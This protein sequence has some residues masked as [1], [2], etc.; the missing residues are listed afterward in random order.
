MEDLLAQKQATDRLYEISDSVKPYFV[1]KLANVK[2][3]L[4]EIEKRKARLQSDSILLSLT[5]HYLGALPFDERKKIRE[6]IQKRLLPEAGKCDLGEVFAV[7]FDGVV[8]SARKLQ[9]RAA[10]NYVSCDFMGEFLFLLG[11]DKEASTVLLQD[12]WGIA[13]EV[14]RSVIGKE[15]DLEAV[16]CSKL[17]AQGFLNHKLRAD[18]I[19]AIYDSLGQGLSYDSD[20]VIRSFG[21]LSPMPSR[22]T[23]LP[24]IAS[25]LKCVIF[26]PN[27][28]GGEKLRT[29]L[30]QGASVINAKIEGAEANELGVAVNK[31]FYRNLLPELH[32]KWSETFFSWKAKLQEEHDADRRIEQLLQ[33]VGGIEDYTFEK[34]NLMAGDIKERP[35]AYEEYKEYKNITMQHPLLASYSN[36]LAIVRSCVTSPV[37]IRQPQE[38]R[39]HHRRNDLFL[40]DIS[41][42]HRPGRV[43]IHSRPQL[44]VLNP[45]TIIVV[46][47]KAKM[48]EKKNLPAKMRRRKI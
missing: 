27:L 43:Q 25:R 12:D 9:L 4:A 16:F 7:C 37:V 11:C 13:S 28:C 8:E 19:V 5:Q 38:V 44:P 32:E 35:D 21:S 29:V 34:I 45:V 47:R 31:I 14:A 10:E 3:A 30:K 33:G 18:G 22:L 39:G 40:E 46:G 36:A 2:A 42:H 20:T 26:Q 23:I 1:S 15:R 24:S 48:R 6:S 17:G 41:R